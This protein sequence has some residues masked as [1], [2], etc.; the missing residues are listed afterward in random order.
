[1]IGSPV[2]FS[3]I[4]VSGGFSCIDDSK[5][6][7]RIPPKRS[8]ANKNDNVLIIDESDIQ[9]LLSDE[10]D[11]SSDNIGQDQASPKFERQNF[12]LC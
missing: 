12:F 10:D 7:L 4:K 8:E 3:K 9:A 6:D 11:E 2:D 5:Y 1:M